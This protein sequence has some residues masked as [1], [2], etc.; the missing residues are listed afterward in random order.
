MNAIPTPIN[1]NRRPGDLDREIAAVVAEKIPGIM[2]QRERAAAAFAEFATAWEAKFGRPYPGRELVLLCVVMF[3][4]A[5]A[6]TWIA[7]HALSR[8]V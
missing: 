7:A 1:I 2:R 3:A 8:A 4:A 6:A 5:G